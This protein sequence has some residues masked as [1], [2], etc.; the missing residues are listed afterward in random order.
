M[1]IADTVDDD[2]RGEVALEY[3]AVWL[4]FKPQGHLVKWAR[5]G[6][7]DLDPATAEHY[8]DPWGRPT[9]APL[10][11]RRCLSASA[12]RD[13]IG[14]PEPSLDIPDNRRRSRIAE[15]PFDSQEISN[16]DMIIL[17]VSLLEEVNRD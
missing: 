11:S 16:I 7:R 15:I 8:L 17:L 12:A 10:C 13:S 6:G 2:R 9:E 1:T 4:R 5:L 3:H 14:S